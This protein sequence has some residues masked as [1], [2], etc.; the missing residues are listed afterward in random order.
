MDALAHRD[1]HPLMD[2]LQD[3]IDPDYRLGPHQRTML[4]IAA[5][6]GDSEIVD[7]LLK[8]GANV[9]AVDSNHDSVLYLAVNTPRYFHHI[10]LLQTLYDHG[11]DVNHSNVEGWTPL[12]RACILGDV[13]LVGVILD[14]GAEV[15]CLN[16]KD[17]IPLQL[18]KVSNLSD[19]AHRIISRILKC[20]S[21]L[22]LSSMA[23][24]LK[25]TRLLVTF[26]HPYLLCV[27]A[28][29]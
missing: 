19:Y 1:T 4:Q 12:H 21:I 17:Q 5:Q 29:E 24:T 15:Y 25:Y 28:G 27:L 14:M 2:V 20:P 6:K 23:N 16:S 9:N 22:L 7:I 18:A 13:E 26:V 8:Y 10:S 3:G 11:A